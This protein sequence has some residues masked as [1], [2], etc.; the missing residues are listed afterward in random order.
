MKL[1]KTS[2]KLSENFKNAPASVLQKIGRFRADAA[3]GI[4]ELQAEIDRKQDEFG[5][6]NQ[7]VCFEDAAALIERLIHSHLDDRRS[8]MF[9]AAASAKHLAYHTD[10]R[11]PSG[12]DGVGRVSFSDGTKRRIDILSYYTEP[13]DVLAMLW[14]DK[15]IRAFAETAARAAGAKTV[16]EGGLP[17]AE[18]LERAQAL[19]AEI[20]S[21]DE[22]RFQAQNVLNEI[23]AIS[24]FKLA[25]EADKAAVVLDEIASEPTPVPSDQSA[26][27]VRGEDGVLRPYR[28]DPFSEIFKNQ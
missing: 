27:Q 20:E 23:A 24:M 6:I 15:E 7:S 5:Q 13:A 26:V 4:S 17:V 11:K 28:A 2:Q 9:S 14:G 25:Q 12:L 1:T 8:L 18:A 10:L 19:V 3:Q 21:L 22:A 16:A